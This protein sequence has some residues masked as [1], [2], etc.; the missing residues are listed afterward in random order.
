[1][2]L[3]KFSIVTCEGKEEY[4]YHTRYPKVERDVLYDGKKVGEIINTDY[5]Q[6]C[7]TYGNKQFL[8]GHTDLNQYVVG[9]IRSFNP[10][11]TDVKIEQWYITKIQDVNILVSP[12]PNIDPQI[13]VEFNAVN[14]DTNN[15]RYIHKLCE[16]DVETKKFLIS[17]EHNFINEEYFAEELLKK[18]QV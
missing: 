2:D 16:F 5:N 1:M 4:P 18:I 9:L 17:D 6:H 14:L 15:Q 7:G 3:R 11:R 12:D 13:F 8:I 10:V